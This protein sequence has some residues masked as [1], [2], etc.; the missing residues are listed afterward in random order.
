[1][2]RILHIKLYSLLINSMLIVIFIF[3]GYSALSQPSNAK[4]QTGIFDQLLSPDEN[5]NK[6]YS[7]SQDEKLEQLLNHHISINKSRKGISG[8]RIQIYSGSGTNARNE[9]LKV[10]AAFMKTF[11][12]IESY[13]VYI[14]P[15]FRVRVGNFRN[16]AE[17]FATFKKVSAVYPQCYFVIEKEMNF[18]ALPKQSAD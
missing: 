18:P 8:Y 1:M 3:S 5:G 7:I 12:D 4:N 2:H 15:N 9:A 13:L 14:E 17:G 11:P 10:Q 16:R 6:L